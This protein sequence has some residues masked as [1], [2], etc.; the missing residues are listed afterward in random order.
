M[1]RCSYTFGFNT[2]FPSRISW[3]LQMKFLTNQQQV[4]VEKATFKS[5][6]KVV[7]KAKFDC[8]VWVI[9]NMEVWLCVM[10]TFITTQ[11]KAAIVFV[12]V[13]SVWLILISNFLRCTNV[14]VFFI[15]LIHLNC[16]SKGRWFLLVWKH[17]SVVETEV[18]KSFK[19]FTCQFSNVVLCHIPLWIV[20]KSFI[21]LCYESELWFII[22]SFQLMQR[23]N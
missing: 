10:K 21:K 14:S 17:C 8:W 11:L 20:C 12:S 2:C 19:T 9:V 22:F 7:E 13:L 4:N 18:V 5:N 16:D 6:S 23:N 15:E 1:S 3:A